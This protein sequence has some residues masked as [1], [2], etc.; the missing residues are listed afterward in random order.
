MTFFSASEGRGNK[1]LPSRRSTVVSV[2]DVGSNKVVCLIARLRPHDHSDALPGRTHAIDL[3]GVGH[4]RSRGI[5][6][7]VVINLDTAEAAIRQAVDTAERMAK[8]TVDSLLV[9]VSCGRLGS[10]TYAAAVGLSGRPVGD[11]DISRV[12]A[13]GAVHAVAR[14]RTSLHSLPVGYSL[15]A[16]RHIRDPR[17][18][19]GATLG[20]DMHMVT[21]DAAPIANLEL[22][23]NRCHLSVARMVAAPYAS[24]LAAMVDDEAELGCVCL[25]F[26]AGTTSIA[27][28]AG[29]HLVHV[30]AIAIGGQH[31]TNDIAR[32][33]SIRLED[34]ERLKTMHGS[35]IALASDD[36]EAITVTPLG[37]DER[38][39]GVQ[40][41]RSTLNRIIKARID[42]TLEVVRDR[43]NASGFASMVGRRLVL[44]G[45]GSQLTGITEAARRI[46]ARDVRHGRPLGVRGMPE[47]AKGP[48]FAGPVGLLIYPQVAE[49]EQLADAP[50]A[51]PAMTGTGG[52]FSR[53]SQWIR[54]SF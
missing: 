43:L 13:A 14:H 24:G 47:L 1:Y 25:D 52:Y 39:G 46:V 15:D 45:G 16:E 33:L 26:G 54:E 34:A 49:F 7:G 21:A 42:E 36:R 4:T 44:T 9:G 18:M 17:G 38:D 27:V 48:A 12:L 31:I 6:S 35:A 30:D 41:P 22:A 37:G 50:L 28:F 51:R 10:E 53:V 3:L 8:V 32:G 5:K 29:G 40:V 11:Q 2:L 19:V 23:V 20:V